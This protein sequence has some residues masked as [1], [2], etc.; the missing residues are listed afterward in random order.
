MAPVREA[1]ELVLAAHDP[2]P[3][4]VVDRH[5]N[6]VA[7]NQ[8]LGLLVAGADPALL[9][10]PVN[11]QRLS[12]HPHGGAPRIVNLGEWRT[13]LL[14]RL[15]RQVAATGDPVL[16]ALLDELG[17]YPA[18]PYEPGSRGAGEIAVTLRVRTDVGELA[19]LSTVATFGTAVEITAA[20][21]G[22]RVVLP[23]RRGDPRGPAPA[24]RDLT[25]RGARRLPFAGMDTGDLV[26]AVRAHR[27]VGVLYRGRSGLERRVL[28]PH[29]VY[30]TSAGVLRLEGVQ[31]GG[32]TS[33][34]SLP[35]WRELELMRVADV[36]VLDT[37]FEPSGD[38]NLAAPRYRHGLIASA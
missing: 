1:V 20:E 35:G 5:W 28:H 10:P 14:E 2:Y 7:G 33:S 27:A 23:G 37:E 26:E 32:A 31:V 25:P 8:G 4:A 34:G 19:F 17:D 21:L 12:L 11:V 13:H 15:A 36:R 24:R 18:P 29:A 3:A 30:R 9:E 22:D 16:A 38:F 6:L